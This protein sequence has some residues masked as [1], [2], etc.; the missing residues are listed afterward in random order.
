MNA[1]RFQFG[2]RAVANGFE[3]VLN[4]FHLHPRP[5]WTTKVHC[6]HFPFVGFKTGP[7]NNLRGCRFARKEPKR[8]SKTELRN[9]FGTSYGFMN[10]FWNGFRHPKNLLGRAGR[11]RKRK[12]ASSA[13]RPAATNRSISSSQQ[14]VLR[15]MPS[16]WTGFHRL[17]Q[18]I[19]INWS[20]EYAN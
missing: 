15:G 1:S 4:G 9:R 17:V 20:F 12:R 11:I 18:N 2:L 13:I 16:L 5:L 7:H 8:S 10:R 19:W 3:T 6:I 14:F